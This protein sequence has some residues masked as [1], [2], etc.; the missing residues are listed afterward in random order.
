MKTENYWPRE[1]QDAFQ[2]VYWEAG[3]L[4]IVIFLAI[5]GPN[6]SYVFKTTTLVYHTFFY[7][8]EIYTTSVVYVK[9]LFVKAYDYMTILGL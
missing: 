9:T 5:P 7:Y 2:W 8:R 3:F 1:I 4:P 6:H